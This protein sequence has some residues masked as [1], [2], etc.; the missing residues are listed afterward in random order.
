MDVMNVSHI[1]LRG[2]TPMAV[3]LDSRSAPRFPK[4]EPECLCS[5]L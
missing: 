2:K 4:R 5:R 1:G 3:E